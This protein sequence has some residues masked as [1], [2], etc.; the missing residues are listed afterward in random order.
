MHSNNSRMVDWRTGT[1]ETWSLVLPQTVDTI[2]M[3]KHTEFTQIYDKYK[4]HDGCKLQANGKQMFVL[5]GSPFQW[6]RPCTAKVWWI[7]GSIQQ[8]SICSRCQ[9][10]CGYLPFRQLYITTADENFTLLSSIRFPWTYIREYFMG[11]SSTRFPL[12]PSTVLV[13]A[14]SPLHLG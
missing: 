2:A 8:L 14:I 4:V 10:V 1:L 12:S 6:L 7:P 3:I 11:C 5:Q 13:V 9:G